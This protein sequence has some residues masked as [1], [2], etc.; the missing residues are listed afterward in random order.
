MVLVVVPI[1][2]PRYQQVAEPL[3]ARYVRATG[4]LAPSQALHEHRKPCNNNNKKKLPL[5]LDI[6][7]I[8]LSF[9]LWSSS[10]SMSSSLFHVIETSWCYLLSSSHLFIKYKLW[11]KKKEK[12]R[13]CSNC[14]SL[15]MLATFIDCSA[16]TSSKTSLLNSPT[17]TYAY[18]LFW[19]LRCLY[20][21]LLTM[22]TLV[23]SYLV[24]V[25]SDMFKR[26][27]GGE[28]RTEI[29]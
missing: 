27:Y 1:T 2:Q 5:K 6:T 20:F 15:S 10:L 11:I 3:T 14:Y 16:L 17:N 25:P 7:I 13:V 28:I 9:S 21:D 18:Q 23:R 22:V 12:K 19:N 24:C 29:P 8:M 26:K 4:N